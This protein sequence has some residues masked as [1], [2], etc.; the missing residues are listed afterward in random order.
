MLFRMLLLLL[1]LLP[2][3]ATKGDDDA[4]DP[5]DQ[6]DDPGAVDTEAGSGRKGQAQTTKG[7]PRQ[8]D[9]PAPKQD[10]KHPQYPF[11]PDGAVVIID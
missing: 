10:E 11:V 7:A 9:D 8:L 6:D 1:S 4:D 3:F 2:L 5:G